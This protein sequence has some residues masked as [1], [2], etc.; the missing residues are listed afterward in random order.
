MT[1]AVTDAVRPHSVSYNQV[2]FLAFCSV[3]VIYVYNNNNF[4]LKYF[5]HQNTQQKPL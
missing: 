2:L 1:W 4:I 5:V 3:I